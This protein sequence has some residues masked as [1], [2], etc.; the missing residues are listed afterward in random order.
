MEIKGYMME[1]N[2]EKTCKETDLN[3]YLESRCNL[4]CRYCGCKYSFGKYK[5]SDD[6]VREILDEAAALDLKDVT[7]TGGGEPTL[8]PKRLIAL[9]EYA[10]KKGIKGVDLVSN[11]TYAKS[12]EEALAIQR[13]YIDVTITIDDERYRQLG[14]TLF[15]YVTNAVKAGRKTRKDITFKENRDNPRDRAGITDDNLQEDDI[16]YKLKKSIEQVLG[17]EFSISVKDYTEKIGDPMVTV[18]MSSDKLK[19]AYELHV[20]EID[21]DVF[22]DRP[23]LLINR[24]G[25]L[26][27]ETAYTGNLYPCCTF[28]V[29]K[30]RPLLTRKQIKI[31]REQGKNAL[32]EA[33]R[34]GYSPEFIELYKKGC[35]ACRLK[36][37]YYPNR[38][39]KKLAKEKK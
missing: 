13:N 3:I 12:Y 7:F 35:A 5:I 38:R 4:K 16:V 21:K 23:C 28:G 29:L 20:V 26:R 14:D 8:N 39:S 32:A 1:K 24:N 30:N 36:K 19:M 15:E 22:K 9:A 34:I 25:K 18:F 17:A 27:L 6:E 10:K 33:I 11:G 37:R 31:L 2:F